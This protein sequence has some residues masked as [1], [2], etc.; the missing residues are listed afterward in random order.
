[1]SFALQFLALIFHFLTDIRNRLYDYGFFS[2]LPPPRPT[3]CVGNLTT[4]G[5]G[6]TP[7]VEFL[8]T[9]LNQKKI[10]VTV[11]SRGYGG[12]YRGVLK[13]EESMEPTLCGEEPLWL[14]RKGLSVYLSRDRRRAIKKACEDSPVEVF[15]LDDGFQHR[16]VCCHFNLILLDATAPLSDYELLP[17]GRLRESVSGL[18]R[19]QAVVIHKCNGSDDQRLNFLKKLSSEFLSS[20]Q[21]FYSRFVFKKWTLL[22]QQVCKGGLLSQTPFKGEILGDESF[23]KQSFQKQSVQGQGSGVL[24]RGPNVAVVCALGNPRSFIGELDRQGLRVHSQAQF[25]FPDHFQWN[26]S[27]IKK[28]KKQIQGLGLRDVIVT[29]KDAVKL[30]THAPTLSPLRIWVCEM[31]VELVGDLEG[32][33]QIILKKISTGSNFSP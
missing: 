29:E 1:M 10:Q 11:V 13:V 31:K 32:F 26:L 4:G 30:L 27:H 6:K 5:V 15:V 18:K 33:L 23:Q 22:Q 8:S 20:E 7:W 9:A 12:N 28:I 25:L 2:S 3:I 14:R 19:A 16:R 21:I 17:R 24:K